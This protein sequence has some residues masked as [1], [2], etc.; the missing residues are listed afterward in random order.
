MER[1]SLPV[2]IIFLG[3]RLGGL[4]AYQQQLKSSLLKE[5]LADSLAMVEHRLAEGLLVAG[6]DDLPQLACQREAVD[7]LA[8]FGGAMRLVGQ[9]L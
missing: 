8:H 9:L 6:W 4:F 5:R 7:G 1:I 2:V 3:C